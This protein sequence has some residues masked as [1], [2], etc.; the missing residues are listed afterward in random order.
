MDPGEEEEKRRGTSNL[1]EGLFLTLETTVSCIDG[2]R[3]S[4]HRGGTD[5]HGIFWSV[6]NKGDVKS[7]RTFHRWQ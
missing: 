5:L 4:Y 7:L 3:V 1:A 6:E 2:R